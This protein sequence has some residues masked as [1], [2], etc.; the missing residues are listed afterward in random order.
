M[1]MSRRTVALVVAVILAAVATVALISYIS[2]E[3]ERVIGQGEAVNV[4][5]ASGPIPSGT[6]AES[7]STRGLIETRAIPRGVVPQGAIGSLAEIQG[8]VA[9][10]SILQDEILVASRW[11]AAGTARQGGIANLPSN[12]VA[13]SV[14]VG[15]VPGVSGFVQ[16]GDRVSILAQLS[17]PRGAEQEN[18]VQFLLQN[19]EVLE[20]G[21]RVINEQ[22]QPTTQQPN[23]KVILT[24]AVTPVQAERL[25]YG[26]FQGQLYFTLLPEGARPADTPGR[27]ARNAFP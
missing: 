3:R 27:T 10:V 12:R 8:K 15:T 21:R 7:A 26:I 16:V 9:G 4:F 18:R 22:G 19:L 5:V 14:E 13:M 24:L 20:A 6:G 17:V 1:S 23:D 2:G 25:A 11:V